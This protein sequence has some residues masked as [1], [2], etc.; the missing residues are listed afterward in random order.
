MVALTRLHIAVDIRERSA[1]VFSI[2]KAYAGVQI[3]VA[4]L[5]VGDYQ[6]DGKC[7]IGCKT[8]T[9][10][11]RSLCDGRLFRQAR[12]LSRASIDS[13]CYILEG[14]ED[15]VYTV[16][17][18]RHAMQGALITLSLVFGIPILRSLDFEGTAR[19]SDPEI[20]TGNGT[21]WVPIRPCDVPGPWDAPSPVFRLPFRIPATRHLG[22]ET[23]DPTPGAGDRW[24]PAYRCIRW[25]PC[26]TSCPVPGLILLSV[27][28]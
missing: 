27:T 23:G 18:H 25:F 15:E 26:P 6:I 4:T 8:I 13:V 20:G 5:S 2:L 12:R 16:R 21:S 1:P 28:S 9:D 10:F 7:L 24:P 11:A 3:T 17:I 14:A 22:P 19:L